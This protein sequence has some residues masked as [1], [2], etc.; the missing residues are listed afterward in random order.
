MQKEKALTVWDLINQI[1]AL[2]KVRKITNK[3]KLIYSS[4]DEWNSYQACVFLPWT[5]QFSKDVE[6][7]DHLDDSLVYDEHHDE[8]CFTY[9]CL[10]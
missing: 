5:L 1:T 4:D 6:Y 8:D 9:L 10:N 3:T 2:K 7:W